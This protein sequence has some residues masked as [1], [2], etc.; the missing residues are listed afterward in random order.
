MYKRLALAIVARRLN[1]N[2]SINMKTSCR[3]M[4]TSNFINIHDLSL[5]FICTRQDGDA[6]V[7][8]FKFCSSIASMSKR[9]V[10]DTEAKEAVENDD[11]TLIVDY[12]DATIVTAETGIKACQQFRRAST[13]ITNNDSVKSHPARLHSPVGDLQSHQSLRFCAYRLVADREDT[14]ADHVIGAPWQIRMQ[15]TITLESTDVQPTQPAIFYLKLRATESKT[16][17]CA[18]WEQAVN[19]PRWLMLTLVTTRWSR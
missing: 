15:L 10:S 4:I 14:N 5:L 1:P 12:I 17:R 3:K 11:H 18:D 6:H 8:L 16:N 9:Y 19:A 7:Q 13:K 2:K